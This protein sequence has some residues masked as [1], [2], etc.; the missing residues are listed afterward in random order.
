MTFI[1]QFGYCDAQCFYIFIIKNYKS[2]ILY[3]HQ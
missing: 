1:L 3:K 2:H